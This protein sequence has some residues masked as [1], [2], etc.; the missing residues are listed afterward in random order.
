[1]LYIPGDERGQPTAFMTV[2][3]FDTVARVNLRVEPKFR[4]TDSETSE[5][6]LEFLIFCQDDLETG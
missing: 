6:L 4:S 2:A 5:F 1:M 3:E